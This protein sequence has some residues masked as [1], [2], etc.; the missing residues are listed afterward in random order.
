[1]R[2]VVFWWKRHVPVP[3]CLRGVEVKQSGWWG[4]VAG[5]GGILLCLQWNKVQA[6]ILEDLSG[7]GRKL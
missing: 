6:V 2:R 1:M 3:A 5:G 4:L 7:R